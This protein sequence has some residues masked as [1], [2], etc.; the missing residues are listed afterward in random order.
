MILRFMR[1]DYVRF[2]ED[3]VIFTSRKF[4]YFY[5][6]PED[7]HLNCFFIIICIFFQVLYKN[8]LR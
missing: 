7:I 5:N 8:I 6:T 4:A 1:T 2:E 3:V